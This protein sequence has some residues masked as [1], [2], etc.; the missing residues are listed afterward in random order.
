M[1]YTVSGLTT[2]VQQRVRDTGYSSSEIL[3]YLNDTQRDIFNEYR[4]PFMETSQDYTLATSTSDITNG[5]GLPSNYVQAINLYLTSSGYEKKLPFKDIREV[6]EY[7]PDPDDTTKHPANVP[8]FWYYY[9]ETIRVYPKPLST[10]TV[11]LRYYKEPTALSADADVPEVPSE[12]EEIMVL[13]AAYRV[14]QVKDN[15]DQAEILQN[16]YDEILQKMVVRYGQ[17]QVGKPTLMR[18]NRN[19]LG[20]AHF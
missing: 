13:G 19:A 15:Y 6:D 16:K 1:A 2:R 17:A 10:Y 7:Y 4:L 11:T 5:S 12:F 8:E 14:L 9:A 3:T 18:I 20:K